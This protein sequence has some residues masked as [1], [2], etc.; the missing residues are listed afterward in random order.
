MTVSTKTGELNWGNSPTSTTHFQVMEANPHDGGSNGCVNESSSSNIGG[1]KLVVADDDDVKTSETNALQS[2]KGDEP[3]QVTTTGEGLSKKGRKRLLKQ[4]LRKDAKKLKK[5]KDKEKKKGTN[6]R[7][8]RITAIPANTGNEGV[9]ISRKERKESGK[10]EFSKLCLQNFTVIIDLNWEELHTEKALKSLKQQVMYCYGFNKRHTL[11][12]FIHLTGLGPLLNEQLVAQNHADNWLGMKLTQSEYINLTDNYS[13]DYDDDVRAGLKKQLVY[14]TSDAEETID[15]LDKNCAYIIGGVVD[16]NRLKG[17]TYRKATAQGVRTVKLPIKENY[18]LSATHILTVNHVF[19]ILLN[20]GSVGGWRKAM[21]AVLPQRKHAK[22][23]PDTNAIDAE[24]DDPI[25][26]DEDGI[27]GS[28]NYGDE[29]IGE[30]KQAEECVDQIDKQ[31]PI[32]VEATT[33][34][35]VSS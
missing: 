17:I 11:P 24:G 13:L 7:S 15:V 27:D 16:R 1:S 5:E 18:A 25:C 28:E 20:Y 14:L 6:S 26:E 12:A 31:K 9:A 21:E 3:D 8:F 30:E 34:S 4:E 2:T 19:E 23:I 35:D 33:S 22:A 29:G 32:G 10:A